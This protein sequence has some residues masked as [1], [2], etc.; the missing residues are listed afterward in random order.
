MATQMGQVIMTVTF[1]IILFRNHISITVI[2]LKI[3]NF[4]YRFYYSFEIAAKNIQLK[5]DKQRKARSLF[6]GGSWLTPCGGLTQLNMSAQFKNN[7]KRISH[8]SW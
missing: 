1:F 2:T 5:A 7:A 8:I 6:T 4:N 3:I